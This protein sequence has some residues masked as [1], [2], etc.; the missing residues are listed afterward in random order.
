MLT[1]EMA[2]YE[3]NA[4][5]VACKTGF[6]S[7]ALLEFPPRTKAKGP[8]QTYPSLVQGAHKRPRRSSVA[9]TLGLRAVETV[10]H[11]PL[12]LLLYDEGT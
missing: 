10:Q 2:C 6:P 4:I 3:R 12:Q 9:Q 8:E 1:T 11:A 5:T 7:S